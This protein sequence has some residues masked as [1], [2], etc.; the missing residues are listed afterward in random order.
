MSEIA[1]SRRTSP[2]VYELLVGVANI[3][4][5]YHGAF[6]YNELIPGG[7]SC[8]DL[9]EG[10]FIEPPVLE[11]KWVLF[12]R[13]R[14]SASD[15]T[16][17]ARQFLITHYDVDLSVPR[18]LV[19]LAMGRSHLP[20][21]DYFCLFGAEPLSFYH[22]LISAIRGVS[23]SYGIH[24][25]LENFYVDE[26]R[27]DVTKRLNSVVVDLSSE[28]VSVR[29]VYYEPAAPPPS[30]D[31]PEAN[32]SPIYLYYLNATS[33]PGD[34][35]P[36]EMWRWDRRTGRLHLAPHLLGRVLTIE[37]D[38]TFFSESTLPDGLGSYRPAD[39]MASEVASIGHKGGNSLHLLM[40]SRF[41]QM[42][43]NEI[44]G[45]LHYAAAHW[46][47]RKFGDLNYDDMLNAQKWNTHL[48][49]RAKELFAGGLA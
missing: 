11:N 28:F 5:L 34:I 43:L 4:N 6:R 42:R 24:A 26:K 31:D 30:D 3:L 36:K 48:R 37:G 25:C 32:D 29:R 39:L 14:V 12:P 10:G 23:E 15:L 13:S 44:E 46:Q 40:N 41:G 20:Y 19:Y 16:G 8:L 9:I 17:V 47:S 45:L 27:D 7:I 35:V 18:A 21:G 49:N 38:G 22:A 2:P 1:S 33:S